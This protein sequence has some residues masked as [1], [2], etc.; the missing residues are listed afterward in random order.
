MNATELRLG[1]L[2]LVDNNVITVESVNDR[3]INI[4]SVGGY[5]VGDSSFEYGGCFDNWGGSYND[6]VIQP[7]PLT[8]EWLLKFGFE[9]TDRDREGL[10]EFTFIYKKEYGIL[11]YE[12]KYSLYTYQTC[13]CYDSQS[14]TTPDIKYVHQLQNLFFALTGE[15]LKYN[16]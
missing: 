6:K 9:K 8:E 7:I 3:G 2:I 14:L 11:F 10:G 1:N 13:G 15:E 16:L 12:N 5:Y 4:E